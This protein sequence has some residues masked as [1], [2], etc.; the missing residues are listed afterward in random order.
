MAN[1][2]T[3]LIADDDR[4][5]VSALETRCLRMGVRVVT[6]YD[7]LAAVLKIK[8]SLP[9]V[10]C[11][12]LNMPGGCGLNVCEMLS[13]D[14]QKQVFPLI[15]KSIPIIAL[16]ARTDEKTINTC[17]E[18]GAWYV[19]K[20]GNLWERLEPLLRRLLEMKPAETN[21]RPGGAPKSGRSRKAAGR[22]AAKQSARPEETGNPSP[23]SGGVQSDRPKVLVIEDDAGIVEIIR[24]YLNQTDFEVLHSQDIEE[25]NALA[26]DVAVVLCDVH[27]RHSRGTSM[28]RELRENGYKGR[29]VV[30]TGDSTSTTVRDCMRADVD[31]LLMKPFSRN[32]LLEKL[33]PV[34]ST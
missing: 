12:D 18:M 33:E 21:G 15:D 28:I 31:E 3:V 6:A 26:A 22:Q 10:V 16:T 24:H 8:E 5:L 34:M 4:I 7:T 17:R 30:I 11:L 20:G 32:D 1:R 29:I 23:S 2:K 25:V 9:D 19:P 27:L 14:A 13:F